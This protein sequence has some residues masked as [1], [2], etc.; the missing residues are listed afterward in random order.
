LIM[1]YSERY[2]PTDMQWALTMELKLS[3]RQLL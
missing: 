2:S 3:C 1:L